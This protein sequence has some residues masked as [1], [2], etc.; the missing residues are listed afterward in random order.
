[1]HSIH[2]V[3][4]LLFDVY[5]RA[6]QLLKGTTDPR[7]RNWSTWAR[8]SRVFGS[9]LALDL[10]GQLQHNMQLSPQAK[11]PDPKELGPSTT[12]RP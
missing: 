11:K 4:I 1:M 10:L 9:V 7:R 12:G 8:G 6:F 3:R 5:S 2:I